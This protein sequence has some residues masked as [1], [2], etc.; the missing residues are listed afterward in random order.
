MIAK[1]GKEN[2][3][4]ATLYMGIPCFIALRFL[5]LPRYCGFFI[6]WFMATPY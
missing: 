4:N 3:G 6:N 1:K 2:G 5:V